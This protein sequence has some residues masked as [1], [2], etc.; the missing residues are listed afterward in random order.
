MV[1]HHFRR[2]L[3]G[4][5]IVNRIGL[6]MQLFIF[7][8]LVIVKGLFIRNC[9]GSMTSAATLGSSD[10]LIPVSSR[11]TFSFMVIKVTH[12]QGLLNAL[13][14]VVTLIGK[15]DL[16]SVFPAQIDVFEKKISHQV[17]GHLHTLCDVSQ[18]VPVLLSLP[19]KGINGLTFLSMT[20]LKELVKSFRL[21]DDS[22]LLN[23]L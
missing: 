7:I 14:R 9:I 1:L 10:W 21:L 19:Q 18:V 20:P 3:Q 4:L 23:G 15:Q 8:K 13:N 2:S 12:S 6:V 17:I 5:G 16:T 11:S 22:D